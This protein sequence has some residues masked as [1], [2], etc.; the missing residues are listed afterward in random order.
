MPADSVDVIETPL[1]L[2]AQRYEVL[3]DGLVERGN[4]K[5]GILQEIEQQLQVAIAGAAANAIYGSVQQIY[6]IDDSLLGIGKSQLLVVVSMKSQRLVGAVFF[7]Q[8]QV[9][10]YLL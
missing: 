1:D 9:V 3:L 4:V 7:V 6:S 8:I 10:G 5:F 2:L